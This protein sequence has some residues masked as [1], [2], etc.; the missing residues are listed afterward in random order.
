MTSL[1]ERLC[2]KDHPPPLAE[3]LHNQKLQKEFENRELNY[4]YENI[5]PKTMHPVSNR[6]HC[7]GAKQGAL[8][9]DALILHPRILE[10]LHFV[11]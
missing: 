11:T 5:V 9:R 6:R 3:L 4:S 1:P 2:Q 10:A 7:C 8:E